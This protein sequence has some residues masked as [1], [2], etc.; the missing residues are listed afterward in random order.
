MI[1]DS[2]VTALANVILSNLQSLRI[3]GDDKITES[4]VTALA[5]GNL[6]NL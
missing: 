6:S 2:G 4:G 5:N 1:T 3:A